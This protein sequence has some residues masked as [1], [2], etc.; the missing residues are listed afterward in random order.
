MREFT[1]YLLTTTSLKGGGGKSTTASALVDAMRRHDLK[2]AAYD[3]DGAIGS[4]SDMH[5]ARDAAWWNLRILSQG[6]SAT[7]FVT[8]A[9]RR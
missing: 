5:A 3:A 4:L 2:I 6:L 9:A 7:I 1:S 8:T